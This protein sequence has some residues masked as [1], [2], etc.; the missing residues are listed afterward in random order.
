MSFLNKRISNA[1]WQNKTAAIFPPPIDPR[2]RLRTRF[3]QRF[4][5]LNIFLSPRTY[6]FQNLRFIRCR[7]YYLPKRLYEQTFPKI[8][9]R[10]EFSKKYHGVGSEETRMSE[11]WH[12]NATWSTIRINEFVGPLSKP[13]VNS[14]NRFGFVLERIQQ[15]DTRSNRELPS[16]NDYGGTRRKVVYKRGAQA[17]QFLS[18]V[19]VSMHCGG[20]ASLQLRNGLTSAHLHSRCRIQ[21]ITIPCALFSGC[22]TPAVHSATS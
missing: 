22:Y 16:S 3:L 21:R 7:V 4:E 8:G 9:N 6:E 13:L 5:N 2:Y 15:C 11:S 19:T 17:T 12:L 18:F 14:T 1:L 20:C 10:L